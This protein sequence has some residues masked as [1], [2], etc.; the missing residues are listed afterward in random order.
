MLQ[1]KKLV[2]NNVGAYK[3]NREIVFE[4]GLNIIQAQ[5]GIGKSTA[6]QMIELLIANQYEGSFSD[7][8]NDDS[9]TMFSSLDFE[10]NTIPYTISISC[11]R[12]KASTERILSDGNG[13][14]IAKGDEAVEKMAEMFDPALTQY[15]LV[16]KQKP[17]DNIVTCKDAER[18]ELFKKIKEINLE[19]YVKQKIEPVIE[20]LKNQITNIE[21]EIYRLEH[22]TYDYKEEAQCTFTEA[23]IVKKR[24]EL[25][26]LQDK[27]ALIESKKA[28]YENK[29]KE[30]EDAVKVLDYN[31][32]ML[33]KKNT[34]LQASKTSI[35]YLQSDS[36][37]EEKQK[38][39]TE[40]YTKE[41]EVLQRSI[42]DLKKKI[43]ETEADFPSNLKE[44]QDSF[45]D[46]DKQLSLIKITKIK[47]D[48]EPL[49]KIEN[50]I[51]TT[52][53]D[54]KYCEINIKSLEK[55]ICPTCGEKC[56][57][58]LQEYIDL[59]ATYELTLATLQESLE[60]EKTEKKKYDDAVKENEENKV[61]RQNLLS[62]KE[63]AESKIESLQD[64]YKTTLLTYKTSITD[65]EEQIAKA[66]I[67]YNKALVDVDASIK[68]LI[69]KEEATYKQ[70]KEDVAEAIKSVDNQKTTIASLETVVDSYSISN[71]DY[72]A[73]ITPIEKDIK[74][75]EAIII[76]NDLIKTENERLV[77]K[78]KEDK[79]ILVEEKKKLEETK[80]SLFNHEQARTILLKDFPNYVVDSSI[81]DVE[82][83]M[84]NFI[85]TVYYKSLGIQLR[86]TK[87]SIKLSYGLNGNEIPAHR[88]SGAESKI[89]SL[90]FINHFNKL[91]NLNLLILDEPDAS[92]SLQTAESLY[93]SLLSMTSI[94]KQMVIVTHNERMLNYMTANIETN[95]IKL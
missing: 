68:E 7:Y 39:L 12:G 91:V 74:D 35:D 1:L 3:G 70:Y 63:L 34:L 30:L 4:E 69:T 17:I 19:K 37:K 22:A 65:K 93:E 80:L 85:D 25:K 18:R 90:A 6:I 32:V 77:L 54:I 64:K 89:V 94:Y 44:L 72:S 28:E 88:L 29:K 71:E 53:Q 52:T 78:E 9:N 20:E 24:K 75:Y 87:T 55:G 79:K 2:L 61:K 92:L 8:I 45:D 49:K 27:Q 76:S 86:S 40:A 51:A 23:E 50:D 82:I 42:A 66:K 84:N 31:E 13:N 47:Y 33:A 16:A 14:Q 26:S 15:S 10:C 46:A 59:K 43:E 95:I 11:K 56:D 58:K 67:N 62:K 73:L 5:N 60:V 21:K 36:Y 83:A 81:E 48:E 38:S 41:V 57:H